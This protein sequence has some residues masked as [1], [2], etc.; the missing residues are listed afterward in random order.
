VI[1]KCF[2]DTETTGL[3]PEGT[4]EAHQ[5][6]CII[7][8]Q[9]LKP[10]DW[11]NLKFRPSEEA[12]M[13]AAEEALTKIGFTRD[14]LRAR[15]LSKEDALDQ[16]VEFLDKH[17]DKYDKKDKMQF[18]AY[19]APFDEGFVRKFFK[20]SSS[21]HYGSYFWNPALC[22]YRAC[23]WLLQ[24]RRDEFDH[25][26][27]RQMCEFAE[28]EFNEDDAHDALYDTKKTVELFKEVM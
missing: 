28:V 22:V 14:E 15:S 7:T 16:F 27:L 21:N 25:M 26:G 4:D 17:V 11:I 24:N 23:A 18:I 10:L 1:K 8:D 6:A 20:Q 13:G 12:I 3:N 2:T 5:I 9:D 19:N